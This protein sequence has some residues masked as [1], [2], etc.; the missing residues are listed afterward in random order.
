MDYGNGRFFEAWA[1]QWKPEEESWGGGDAVTS[2]TGHLTDIGYRSLIC[3]VTYCFGASRIS[4]EYCFGFKEYE[5]GKTIVKG[6]S[7]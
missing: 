3:P 4:T 5:S 6:T 2:T 7:L 1:S